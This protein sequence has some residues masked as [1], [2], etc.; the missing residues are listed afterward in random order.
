MPRQAFGSRMTTH[1]HSVSFQNF[2]ELFQVLA[3]PVVN[4]F[5]TFLRSLAAKGAFIKT[6]GLRGFSMWEAGG[7]FDD[8]LLDS[9]RKGTGLPELSFDCVN[10]EPV[11]TSRVY[12]T[13]PTPTPTP[14]TTPGVTTKRQG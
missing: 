11:S 1:N 2:R 7:D 13:Y 8:I 9:I 5:L 10:G 6:T 4:R 3:P 12:P 14:T